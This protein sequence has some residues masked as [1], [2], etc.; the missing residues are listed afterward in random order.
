MDHTVTYE[1]SNL[2]SDLLSSSSER[3]W[4][5]ATSWSMKSKARWSLCTQRIWHLTSSP[6]PD[7]PI[8]IR[9]GLQGRTKYYVACLSSCA[10]L[11]LIL[12]DR[13]YKPFRQSS[14]LHRVTTFTPSKSSITELCFEERAGGGFLLLFFKNLHSFLQTAW[15]TWTWI[16]W[17]K[18]KVPF[19][20]FSSFSFPFPESRP[21]WFSSGGSK[22]PLKEEQTLPSFPNQ[23][24][25][26]PQLCQGCSETASGLNS[27]GR[28]GTLG[29]VQLGSPMSVSSHRFSYWGYV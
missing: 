22:R 8:Q 24:R 23:D 20:M 1:Y 21:W 2:W 12:I 10:I 4:G 25:M 29:F 13:K 27:P 3:I 18:T 9:L 28:E 14:V 5:K 11:G 19:F 16:S 7:Q 26:G 6:H 15:G 17:A